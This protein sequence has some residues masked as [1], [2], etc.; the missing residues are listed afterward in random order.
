MMFLGIE[1]VVEGIEPR[2]LP[3][4]GNHSATALH[5]QPLEVVLHT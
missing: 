2:N 5:T 1:K 3:L 4:K